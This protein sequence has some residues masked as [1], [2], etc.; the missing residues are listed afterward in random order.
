MRMYLLDN[1]AYTYLLT[2]QVFFNMILS[3]VILTLVSSFVLDPYVTAL[4]S[5]IIDNGL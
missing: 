4:E 5:K 2:I 1:I 3:P